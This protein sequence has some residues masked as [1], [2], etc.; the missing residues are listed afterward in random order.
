KALFRYTQVFGLGLYYLLDTQL[1][2]VFQVCMA[3]QCMLIACVGAVPEYH[4]EQGDYT[5]HEELIKHVT[6]TEDVNSIWF[7]INQ[8]VS[9]AGSLFFAGVLI[10]RKPLCSSMFCFGYATAF[11]PSYEAFALS[12]LLMGQINGG[13]SL[14]CFMLTQEYV[15]KAYW[16][17]TGTNN[18]H[19]TDRCLT[20]PE[21][22]RWLYSRDYT[23][24]AEEVLQY[25]AVRNGNGNATAKVKLR[26][27]WPWS[28]RSRH[29]PSAP[30]EDRGVMYVWY[31]CSLVYN[32]LIVNAS[33]DDGN[34]Y[35][36]VVMYGLVELPAYPL[37]IYFIYK[38]FLGLYLCTMLIP[39]NA[40]KGIPSTVWY[41][42]KRSLLFLD[43]RNAGLGVCSMSC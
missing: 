30:L 7:L 3:C 36:S 34:R 40:G 26:Q 33:E 20:L 28:P 41:L 5:N 23:E 10:E 21:S 9:L 22:P 19:D 18:H 43:V 14:V 31:S 12:C 16:A 4:I 15:G 13:M 37:C 2:F 1:G 11:A 25:M 17:M 27:R 8:Q 6:F 29:P 32:G 39:V 42:R 24:Q 35:F 38:H